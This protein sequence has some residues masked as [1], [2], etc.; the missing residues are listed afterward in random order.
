MTA[1]KS[2]IAASLCLWACIYLT[3]LADGWKLWLCASSTWSKYQIFHFLSSFTLTYVGYPILFDVLSVSSSS[4]YFLGFTK[5]SWLQTQCFVSLLVLLVL[6][7]NPDILVYFSKGAIYWFQLILLFS[8]GGSVDLCRSNVAICYLIFPVPNRFL[9]VYFFSFLISISSGS[10]RTAW[11]AWQVV[12]IAIGAWCTVRQVLQQMPICS[13]LSS[14]YI[15]SL[16]YFFLFKCSDYNSL[17][18]CNGI[19]SVYT[20]N[21]VLSF[22]NEQLCTILVL[23]NL[24]QFQTHFWYVLYLIR[25]WAIA[26]QA[27]PGWVNTR[28]CCAELGGQLLQYADAIACRGPHWPPTFLACFVFLF[29]LMNYWW[30]WCTLRVL[31]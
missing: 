3:I 2:S 13:E 15:A 21:F 22:L 14:T 31:S 25:R 30:C 29:W 8:H 19:F 6:T 23:H 24:F 12:A 4:F 1:N 27:E 5:P 11:P 9:N 10:N 18:V 26:A 28:G 16:N 17:L 7:L 20:C